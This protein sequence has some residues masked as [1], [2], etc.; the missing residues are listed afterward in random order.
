MAK[1]FAKNAYPL[2]HHYDR[3]GKFDKAVA[4]GIVAEIIARIAGNQA[5]SGFAAGFTNEMLV[6]KIK[7]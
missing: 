7:E 6:N 2:L 3:D 4:H 1:L 5:G